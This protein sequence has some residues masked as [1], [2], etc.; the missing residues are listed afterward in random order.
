LLVELSLPTLLFH[1]RVH[2]H[3]PPV[4]LRERD[5]L[6]QRVPVTTRPNRHCGYESLVV[7]SAHDRKT[8]QTV[9]DVIG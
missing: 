4:D 6:V 9:G 7:D 2:K 8:L 5:G 3:V 1:T